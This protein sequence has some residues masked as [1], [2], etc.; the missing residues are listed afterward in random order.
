[1]KS[2][3][4]M[5]ALAI[6]LAACGQ[7]VEVPPATEGKILTQNGYLPDTYTP[8]VFRLEF[9][10]LPGQVC[11]KLILV[12]KSDKSAKESFKLLM[13]KDQLNMRFDLRMTASIRNNQTDQI[14]AKITPE[15]ISSRVGMIDFNRV[16]ITYA[17]PVI[18]EV[19]RSVI[20]KYS[21]NEINSSRNAVNAELVKAL[22]LALKSTPIKLKTVGLADIQFPEFITKQK[23][24]SAARREAIKR[25][26]AEK[27]IRLIQLETELAAAKANR[28]VRREKALAAA[29]END[30]FAKSVTKE[31]LEYKKLE[32]LEKLAESGSSVFVP[33]NALDEV[34]LSQKVF[35]K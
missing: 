10:G 23:E 8:S 4:I 28:A 18:R 17:Q 13:P 22:E 16:Y 25:E 15:Y 3:L 7:I 14:L 31:Y 6:S 20:S 9:C 26:Q 32:V 21:I 11:D 35:S 29:E 24:E 1:M 33:F 2:I 34:G 5:G 12:D 19:T 30:I 27:Q